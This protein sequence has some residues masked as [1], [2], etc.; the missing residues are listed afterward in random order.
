MHRKKFLQYYEYEP[1][2]WK[3]LLYRRFDFEWHFSMRAEERDQN[4]PNTQKKYGKND[5]PIYNFQTTIFIWLC[6]QK[7]NCNGAKETVENGQEIIVTSTD[8]VVV[9][10]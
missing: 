4:S 7:K 5:C 2:R 9:C 1:F 3:T 10:K 6:L 8:T